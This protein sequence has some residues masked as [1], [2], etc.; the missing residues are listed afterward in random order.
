M[1]IR[2]ILIAAAFL[3]FLIPQ[4]DVHAAVPAEEGI[5]D[6]I[7][8]LYEAKQEGNEEQLLL[9]GASEVQIMSDLTLVECGLQE[10]HNLQS[11]IYQ[12]GDGT[13]LVV[14]GY[15]ME[16]QDVDVWLPGMATEYII[17][18]EQGQYMLP[19]QTEEVPPMVNKHAELTM[20]DP[21]IVSLFEACN[22]SYVR[23]LQNDADGK[24][25][26]YNEKVRETYDKIAEQRSQKEEKTYEVVPGDC[27]WRIAK[28]Y[29][30]SG[31]NWVLLYE[32]NRAVIGDSP[33]LIFPGQQLDLEI[34]KLLRD[35]AKV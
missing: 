16:V 29:L 30:G 28:K 20:T 3:A 33:D 34:Y 25:Q 5:E 26:D 9:Y 22:D 10:Y 19:W 23:I 8:R 17:E 4:S 1:K 27:L 31:R 13:W 2:S 24:V 21:E 14:V 7:L 6:F 15:E 11:H 35:P 32:K 18:D 12:S